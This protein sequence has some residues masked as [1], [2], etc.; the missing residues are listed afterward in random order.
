MK[1]IILIRMTVTDP[2]S[3]KKEKQEHAIL[4]S[5]H[6]CRATNSSEAP[7]CLPFVFLLAKQRKKEKTMNIIS[8]VGLSWD[9]SDHL[10]LS[11]NNIIM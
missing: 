1:E 3:H 7:P 6:S 11:R 8:T 10:Q 9:I 4:G 2:Q 5:V